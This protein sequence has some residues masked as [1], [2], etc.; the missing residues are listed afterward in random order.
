M[1]HMLQSSRIYICFALGLPLFI[2]IVTVLSSFIPQKCITIGYY[3]KVDWW[4]VIQGWFLIVY[5]LGLMLL[6]CKNVFRSGIRSTLISM[7]CTLFFLEGVW[8]SI[9]IITIS[10]TN[11]LECIRDDQLGQ[12]VMISLIIHPLVLLFSIPLLHAVTILQ[13]LRLKPQQLN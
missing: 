11:F 5:G 8:E 6:F 10:R 3:F 13:D 9:G 2:G 1:F 12:A 7:T 4:L